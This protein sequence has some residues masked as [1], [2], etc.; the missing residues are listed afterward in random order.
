MLG[1]NMGS[2]VHRDVGDLLSAALSRVGKEI[3]LGISI[4][5]GKP[6]HFA[7][8]LLRDL[9]ERTVFATMRNLLA[10]GFNG[11]CWR[12]KKWFV[13]LVSLMSG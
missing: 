5:I 13:I 8:A 4:A 2:H 3:I 9:S 6:N 12:R 1:G 7:N 10:A 11:L